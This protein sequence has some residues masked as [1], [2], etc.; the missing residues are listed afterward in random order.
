M[1]T[2]GGGTKREINN[3]DA[4]HVL[5]SIGGIVQEEVHES[6]K[7]FR[8]YLKGNLIHANG[9]GE[10]VGTNKTCALVKEYISNA[11]NHK[12]NPCR[13]EGKK[14]ETP[15]FSKEQDDKYDEKKIGCSNSEGGACAPL[16]RLSLC[17]KNMEN[18]NN[19]D[20][21]KAKHDLLAEVCYAAKYE[22]ETL[23]RY[24]EQ[25]EVEYPSD[26]SSQLCTMLARS[27][28]D[29]GD[30]VRGKD[31]F[32]GY[33]RNDVEQ[34]KRLQQNLKELFGKIY[35]ELMDE[36]NGE[37]KRGAKKKEEAKKR[38]EDNDRE[39]NYFQLREDWWDAN[40]A[41]IWQA[42][43]CSEELR[44][45][46]YFRSTCDKG[47]GKGENQTNHYC[48]C[49]GDNPEVDNPNTDPPTY[50]DYVPQFLRWF[51]EWAEDFCRKKRK[52]LE[53]VKKKCRG[54]YQGKSRYC[55]LNGY[56]CEQTV[57][58]KSKLRY[59][60]RCIECSYACHPYVEWI[61][62]KREEFNKQKEKYSEQIKV[63]KEEALHRIGGRRKR[64]T[65]DNYK[66]NEKKFYEKLKDKYGS[67]DAFLEKLNDENDCKNFN[68][69]E[70]GKINFNNT[71]N[72]NSKNKTFNH[73]EYCQ[74]CPY[75][76]MKKTENEKFVKKSTNDDCVGKKLYKPREDEEGTKMEILKSGDRKTEI[77]QKLKAF[78]K[79]EIGSDG[80]GKNGGSDSP[81]LKEEW[82]CY[83]YEQLERIIQKGEGDDD[84]EDYD[85]EVKSAGGLCILQKSTKKKEKEKEKSVGN[86]QR[87]PEEIQKTFNNF[88][89][90]WV[91]HMLK[92]SIYWKNELHKCIYNTNGNT[93]RSECKNKCGCFG[94]W[95]KQKKEEWTKIKDH[96]GKQKDIIEQTGCNPFVTLEMLLQAEFS[97]ENYEE[98]VENHVST[99]E[100]KEIKH[101]QNILQKTGTKVFTC[102]IGDNGA[103]TEQNTIMDRL[104]EYEEGEA[105]KCEKCKDPPESPARYA[106]PP[107][108]HIEEDEDEI[109][110]L[111]QED[112]H[113]PDD[114]QEEGSASEE[115]PEQKDTEGGP[116]ET[117]VEDPKVCDI[118]NDILTG[119]GNLDDACKQKYEKGR[120]RYTQWKCVNP[121]KT[122]S[123]GEGKG[124]SDGVGES[125]LRRL[126]RDLASTQ[127]SGKSDSNGSICIPP[128]RRRLYTK[129]IVEWAKNYNKETTGE[130]KSLQNRDGK[131]VDSESSGSVSQDGASQVDGKGEAGSTGQTEEKGPKVSQTGDSASQQQQ[132]QQALTSETTVNAASSTSPLDASHL[133]RQAFI[134]SAAVETFFLWDR[135]KKIKLK[136]DKEQNEE[137]YLT[138]E[139]TPMDNVLQLNLEKEGT[140]PDEFKRQMFY[141][142]G[143]Y[144]DICIGIKDKELLNALDKS[145]YKDPSDDKET[146]SG[147]S[148]M[149][150]IEKSIN[151]VFSNSVSQKTPGGQA[152]G[153]N[154]PKTWWDD[155]AKHIWEGM[156][157]ALTYKETGDKKIEQ[158][159][160]TNGKDNLFETIKNGNE[161]DQVKLDKVEDSGA[162]TSGADAPL[163]TDF[164]K[165][166]PYFRWLEEWGETFCGTRK[167]LL[168]DVKDNCRDDDNTGHE[169][170]GGDGHD[171]RL[172]YLKHNN[173]N[174]NLDCPGCYKK[175][176]KYK[177]WIDIKFH[178]YHKQEKK[179]KGE[180]DKLTNGGN[181]SG[182]GGNGDNKDFCEQIKEKNTAADF[183]KSL[184]HCKN[185]KGNEDDNYKEDKENEIDFTKITQTFSP[186]TYCKACPVYGV[187][188]NGRIYTPTEESEYKSRKRINGRNDDDT[189]PEEIKVLVLGRTAEVKEKYDDLK[190]ACKNTGLLED[191]CFQ[192]WNCQKK[193]GI[194]ECTIHNADTSLDPKYFQKKI[195]FKILFQS[196]IINFIEYFNKSKE[197]IKQCTN[198]KT[199]CK[200]LCNNKCDYVKKWLDIKEGEW[201]IIKKYYDD[202]FKD[203][204]EPIYSR[205]KSFLEQGPF[206]T[207][208]K[209][210][211]KVV[212]NPCDRE[213]LWGCTGS[214]ECT[215]EQ[216]KE[217]KDF[218]T[219][220]IDKLKT[221]ATSCPSSPSSQ[222]PETCGENSTHVEDDEEPFEEEDPDPNQVAQPG[223]CPPTQEPQEDKVL[224]Q[225]ECKAAETPSEDKKEVEAEDK[226]KDS[227]GPAGPPPPGE[228]SEDQGEPPE[229][230]SPDTRPTPTAPPSTPP[231]PVKP[232]KQGGRR[233]TQRRVR[234]PTQNP[235]DIHLT[236]AVIPSLASSTLA[237]SVGI[238][239]AAISY[240][241]LKKKTKRPV[242][243]FT[244]LEIP[245]NDYEI[246]TLKS[247][248]K[249]IPYASG[250]YR[251]KRYVYIEGDSGTDSGYTDHYSDI[252]SSSESEYEEFD[253]NDIYPYQSPKYKTLIEVVL[254][255]SKKDIPSS[256]TTPSNK[257]T[258]EEWNQLKDDFISNMLQNTQ[259]ND[260]PNDYTSGDIPTNTNNTT[261]SRHNV[262]NN[263]HP[264]PSRHNVDNN[265]HPTTSHDNVDNNTHPTMSSHN[266]D[267]NTHPTPS[268]DT[269]DQKPFIMSIHDRNLLSG[270]E[271][272][273]D[274]INNIGNND[275]YS[276]IDPKRGDNV[277]Y[278][279]NHYPY[280]GIDLINDTLS[281]NKHIDIYDEVLKRKENE[282]FGTNNPKRTSTYSVAKNTNSDPIDSQLNL[283]HKWLDRHRDMCQQWND[284]ERLDKLKEK[285]EKENNSGNKT[286][287]N[288]TPTSDNTTPNSDIHSGK[289]SDIPSGKLSDTPSGK[290]SDIPSGK[291][292]DIP[293][294]KLSDIPSGN[295]IH[296]DIQTSDIHSG[297]LSDIHSG[298]LSG[299]PSSNKMLNTD[300]S[301][302]IDM[303]IHKTTNIVDTTP[304]KS[305][306]DTVLEDLD[307]YNEP[308]Y[309]VQDDIYYDVNGDDKTSMDN[310]NNL[311]HK[312]NLVDSN[313]STYNHRN[314]ADINK[315][316]V[317]KNNQNQHLIEK[318]TKIQIEM[319]SNNREVVE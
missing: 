21:E 264:T 11:A 13:K 91:T 65:T 124:G 275:L 184:K 189:I 144:R 278:S 231:P 160:D 10:T 315:N 270:E 137:K 83:K 24:R 316:S 245:Q 127:S 159:K 214:N 182:S 27:F 133:L 200:Q 147:E 276:G 280:S 261:T 57:R 229:E 265:T 131:G 277:L 8:D 25:Y 50:F 194:H 119:S 52:K 220:L 122:N 128:R 216:E 185:D 297:K 33:N 154:D 125:G 115:S 64:S 105:E 17:N 309:D 296:S 36:L 193:N 79:T 2:G 248:N 78:C 99:E 30:I 89:Y 102:V 96:F 201:K 178:E 282:I 130:S 138:G 28:A 35:N 306:M 232:P 177:K 304:N 199:S 161:Y 262:D 254:A 191:T 318:P 118:V 301:I 113:G 87:E 146:H 218:I 300:A 314:P 244:V 126:K 303:D 85:F 203:V 260:L 226:E 67:V 62:K 274:M 32:R 259:P 72:S 109:E 258:E 291:I 172:E 112:D 94:R 55:S 162:K 149:E 171:C 164:I 299:I 202:H 81:E 26:S 225:E 136:E 49:N 107:E 252:T 312:N 268:R 73:S 121:T 61:D 92:D 90:Y 141:T 93:C 310:N 16:R 58:A 253:I 116:K 103:N 165:R 166:P 257:F 204:D 269:L 305:T 68:D 158:I 43:T 222:N 293:S 188:R 111:D 173:I 176:R 139:K 286:S 20:N 207:D 234:P 243:L 186:S 195:S 256:D 183:L 217:D 233:R 267:N 156:I 157:C 39:K 37:K 208:Y 255:P 5:D 239:F 66:G 86:S 6:A 235:W 319:N 47:D 38:Y 74:P 143:D 292:S 223:F 88:F 69:A 228:A 273:Y 153:V 263:T 123:E 290:L 308:Y 250:K 307:K 53:N 294:G 60:N 213:Q 242:D 241:L 77:E 9:I 41:T 82:K 145:V 23:E 18:R 7:E 148:D 224:D 14:E 219:N 302:Q 313:N 40:R 295:N 48:R 44:D 230:K 281:G 151:S 211:Q 266:V 175:C 31:L 249:Y 209:K 227:S 63:Y 106:L 155:N 12:R 210:A 287:G 19:N 237:W 101:M 284:N 150:K 206:D 251:G 110:V 97:N 34:K 197:I 129:K 70:E 42:I 100:A 22:G 298:K 142:L 179:Y 140:I 168:K 181:C 240:F 1:V 279:G 45:A 170:C 108:Q 3:K 29:I 163:L 238:A 221:K 80:R 75:C 135:Y 4:K 132:Q 192:K 212:K 190:Y 283:F 311:V 272:N 236:S 15:R 46:S 54:K 289:L 247:S 174:A 198:D 95:V 180:H 71:D 56:D 76:G 196:W 215:S 84:D 59:G 152:N 98:D 317:D 205:I 169:Y 246:P 271:Y 167:R 187:K 104:I 120:E 51:E 134:E 114:V 117:T 285:W 288:I